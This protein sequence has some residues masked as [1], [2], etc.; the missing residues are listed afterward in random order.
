MW[1]FHIWESGAG[2]LSEA[3]GLTCS[4]HSWKSK[5]LYHYFFFIPKPSDGQGTV[6]LLRSHS[7]ILFVKKKMVLRKN[8][9]TSIESSPQSKFHHAL[10]AYSAVFVWYWYLGERSVSSWVFI[11]SVFPLVL[12]WLSFHEND[13]YISESIAVNTSQCSFLKFL[14]FFL[15]F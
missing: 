9:K 10:D 1:I 5:S 4:Y 15:F 7:L 12:L 11:I 2:S 6:V 13:F 3:S 14:Y 8:G